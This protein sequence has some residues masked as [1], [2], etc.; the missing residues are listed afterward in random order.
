MFR[1]FALALLLYGCASSPAVL[2]GNTERLLVEVPEGWLKLID[3]KVGTLQMAEYYP[4]KVLENSSE[5]WAE[6]LTIEALSG[7]DL[8]DPLVFAQGLADDQKKLCDNFTDNSVFAGFEN[9]Y[10]TVVHLT[11]C[12]R[13][14]NT[15]R[16]VV[17]MLKIIQGNQSL[18]TITRIWRL[19]PAAPPMAAD[20]IQMDQA[21]LGAWSHALRKV[22]VCDPA[23]A[24][25]P[26]P[27][28]GEG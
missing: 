6:K 7:D 13:N 20:T 4:A 24:A 10:P 15:G 2:A 19:P 9:G 14:Q 8:P 26:C 18:Y 23:L 3:R 25:H 22:T 16:A 21:Q 5:D 17:M 1:Q 12:G 28:E 11:Q 27:N